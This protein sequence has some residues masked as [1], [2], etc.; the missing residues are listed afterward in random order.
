VERSGLD[1]LRARVEEWGFEIIFI[2]RYRSPKQKRDKSG[3]FEKNQQTTPRTQTQK[4][5]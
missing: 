4:Q 1:E 3:Q 5:N 2:R